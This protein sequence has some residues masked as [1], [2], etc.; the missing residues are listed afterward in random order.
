[1]YDR[2]QTN[3]T[4]LRA[5]AGNFLFDRSDEYAGR[6]TACHFDL[7]MRDCTVELDGKA[8]VAR[9]RLC[10]EL[11]LNR[12]GRRMSAAYITFDGVRVAYGAETI[13]DDLSFSVRD[14]EFLC[15][16][17]PS[18]CGKSTTL[19]LMSG[20]L[21]PHGGRIYA[22]VIPRMLTT[23]LRSYFNPHGWSVG[24]TRFET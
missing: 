19:R 22:A 13:F 12:P 23:I 17:G 5:F 4:E 3:G 1:M 24:A 20:L 15:L 16:L 6:F 7:P 21:R 9:G 8:V 14:G 10:D 2:T 11:S 18:G